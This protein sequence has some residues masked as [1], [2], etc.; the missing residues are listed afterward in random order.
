MNTV[1]THFYNEEYM[2]P[3]WINHHKKLFDYGIMINHGSTDRSVEICK[4][5]CPHNWKIVD[6]CIS[7]FKTEYIDHEVKFYE[8]TVEGSKMVLTLTEFFIPS[9]SL[10]ELNARM[11]QNDA[12][13]M[14]TIGVCMVDV[15]PDDLPSYDKS[16]MEQKNHG[17]ISGYSD[18]LNSYNPDSYK[19]MYGRFYHNDKFGKY[20]PGRHWLTID[21]DVVYSPEDSYVMKYKYSPWNETSINRIMQFS[22]KITMSDLERGLCTPHMLVK[23]E[24]WSLYS[25]LRKTAY[26]LRSDSAFKNAYNY[27]VNL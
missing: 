18:P 13:Y 1:I 25:Y 20:A 6:T 5:M 19:T 4:Q 8:N 11:K 10:N 15:L 3:W 16:L 14:K 24:H 12:N 7:E 26:N 9:M 17:M 21:D 22:S 2:L 27:C 23:D